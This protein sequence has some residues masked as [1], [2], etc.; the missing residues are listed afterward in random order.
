M[1]KQFF[2]LFIFSLIF[3]LSSAS[4]QQVKKLKT[5]KEKISYS[6]GLGVGSN[7]QQQGLDKEVIQIQALMQGISDIL[8]NKKLLLSE[9]DI[10]ETMD[11]FKE[12]MIAKI[13]KKNMEQGKKNAKEGEAFL[14]K[15]KKKRNVVTL[16]SGLQYQVIKEGSGDTP[17]ANDTVVT[18]YKGTLIDGTVFDSS[19][20][21][22]Q[23]ATFPVKNVI[24]GWTEALQLMK[25]GSKW[26]LFIPSHL[27]YGSRGA[28]RAIGPNST[29]IF[30]IELLE[31]KKL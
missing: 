15:N 18:H 9:S 17:S 8:H 30:D 29:L 11:R 19:Y 31:V 5:E 27:A 28:G 4:A 1:K 21:R 6:I 24:K 26:K 13:E 25:A 16:A 14:S 2:S 12:Q 22:K 3:T 7:L 20:A 23:P 10:K